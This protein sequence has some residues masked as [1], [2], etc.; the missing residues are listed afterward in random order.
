[1]RKLTLV[2]AGMLTTLCGTVKAQANTLAT[3]D[4]APMNVIFI[5]ADDLGWSDTTLYGNTKLY[6]TPNLE[7][8]SKRGMTFNRAYSN[9]PLCSPT[10][11]SILTGQNPTRHGSTAPQHHE[12]EIR[13][14][15]AMFPVKQSGDK[16]IE[17]RSANRLVTSFPTLGKL[18]KKSGMQ[19]AH[20]GKW[21]LGSEPY[22]P[23]EHGFDIDIPHHPGPGPAGGYIAPWGY[24]HMKP[25]YK[26]EHIE[27]RMAEEAI[28]WLETT[29]KTKPFFLNYWQ[30][31]VHAPF[32]AKADLIEKYRKKIDKNSPQQSPTYA[33]MVHSFD[34]AVGSLLDALDK[35]GLTDSTVIIFISD[36]GGHMYKKIKQDGN[37]YATSNYPLRGGK[38][39]MYEG[40]IRVPAIVV[41]PGVTK[42]GSRSDE[43]IQASDFYPTLLNG[44][45][46]ELPKNHQL[47]G[48][49]LKP[50]LIGGEL[51]R[52][53]IF[54][55]FPHS[56][57]IPSWLP[58]SIAV[59]A[60]DWK[61][62]RIFHGGENEQHDYKLYNLVD[63]IGEKNNLAATN[64]E[65]VKLLDA[66]IEAHL[67]N[68]NAIVPLP[69]PK[70]DAT[71]YFPEEIGLTK[72]QRNAAKSKNKK[73]TR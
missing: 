63:D 18:L 50:A 7:R 5:L 62:I 9:S 22:S 28:S 27:D 14:Q 47:D 15:A 65:R 54:T 31:S 8:L 6:E 57:R 32:D 60:G 67:R 68:A 33:A 52:Q 17:V 58:P 40:G 4:K 42:P 64:P 49:D 24:R 73:N 26:G 30:F 46:V 34:D 59:H 69:N 35:N 61:L 11:A 21:H 44:L 48:I 43:V 36:N 45:G 3:D 23:L 72:G 13:L 25:N 71:N 37:V 19:T 51:D 2:I 41:W 70:F 55:Y 16:Q 20:F 38:A 56:P 12:K 10:R 66:Q 39:T 1:M 29:D 53:A